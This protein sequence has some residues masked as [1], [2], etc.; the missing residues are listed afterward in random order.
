MLPSSGE[1]NTPP[2]HSLTKSNRT[3]KLPQ[4][5]V[6]ETPVTRK[7]AVN[8][9]PTHSENKSKTK[10]KALPKFLLE[11]PNQIKSAVKGKKKPLTLY[12]DEGSVSLSETNNSSAMKDKQS[13][14]P[15]V[16]HVCKDAVSSKKVLFPQ[17]GSHDFKDIS[18]DFASLSIVRK[19]K[20][21]SGMKTYGKSNLEG[22]KEPEFK[23]PGSSSLTRGSIKKTVSSTSSEK[24][25]SSHE[26][27]KVIDDVETLEEPVRKVSLRRGASANDLKKQTSKS[28]L[29]SSE[30]LEEK[31]TRSCNIPKEDCDIVEGTPSP[32]GNNRFRMKV[33]RKARSNKS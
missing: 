25:S 11:T 28:K 13:E 31:K 10:S 20:K 12:D 15:R 6:V 18:E 5:L 26:T 2:T 9:T 27:K 1:E 32:P 4:K 3:S 7:K 22:K 23:H 16:E 33:T 8:A 30:P 17:S 21:V 29:S 14:E 19:A 24:G